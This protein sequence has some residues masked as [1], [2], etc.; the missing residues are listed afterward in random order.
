M[1]INSKILVTGAGGLVGFAIKKKLIE[2]GYNN[3]IAPNRSDL[4]LENYNEVYNYFDR[5]RPEYIFFAA[6]KVGGVLA[7][8]TYP[9]EFITRNL[10][11][12]NNVIPLSHKF[13]VTKLLFLASSSIYPMDSKQPINED[14]F[15]NGK[16]DP[17]HFAYSTAKIAGI[18]MCKAYYKQYGSMFISAIPTNVY[19]PNDRFNDLENSHVV[20]ALMTK[21]ANAKKNKTAL[22]VWGSGE[23]RRDLLY[24]EDLAEACIYLM[25]N[26]ESEEIINIGSGS[27]VSIKELVNAIVDVIGFEEEIIYDTTK[28][29]GTPKRLLD[30][31]K[32]KKIGWEPMVDLMSGLNKTYEWFRNNIDF[33]N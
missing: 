20:P 21:F 27:D 25:N 22:S 1:D 17:S 9:A 11:I 6:A 8:K 16:L 18:Q 26:Y 32:I 4:D 28:P 12:Q 30:I 2:T 29:E 23:S 19:G 13:K 31:S 10:I 15:M 33:E 7:N 14:Q 3:I 5:E 24:S